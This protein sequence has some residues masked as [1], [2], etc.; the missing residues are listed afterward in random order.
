[1]NSTYC[2]LKSLN[3]YYNNKPLYKCDYCGLTVALDNADTKIL[4]F[5]KM[6]DI[7]SAIHNN[8]TGNSTT[9]IFHVK[10]NDSLGE[11]VL[12]KIQED[13]K[14]QEEENI[15]KIQDSN[16][17]DNL[18]SSEQID[19]RL[20]ICNT[21]EYFQNNSCLLCGCTVIRE[22]NYQNK[23]AHKDQKCPVGKWDIIPD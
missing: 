16:N 4:C 17:P 14:I 15:K 10:Q 3:S 18:C 1:M 2:D 12:S 13:S 8:H 21:C 9:N 5:K 22:A 20:A 19:N 6:E 7:S 23:L 11:S